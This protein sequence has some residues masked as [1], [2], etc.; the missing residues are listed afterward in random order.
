MSLSLSPEDGRTPAPTIAGAQRADLPDI[1]SLLDAAGLTRD[2]VEEGLDGFVA[3]REGNRLVAVACLETHGTAGLLRSVA[4]VP[5]RRNRGFAGRL[6][7]T[8]I[9]RSRGRKHDAIYLLTD[10]APE[11][12]ERRGF[13]R[14]ERAEVPAA[15]RAAGQF[16]GQTCESATVM[17]LELLQAQSHVEG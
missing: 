8:L 17:V 13:R 7:E 1:Y 14:I 5:D 2:G 3:A 4:T 12:F 15:V 10:T 9:E 6:V 16:T 11:Y